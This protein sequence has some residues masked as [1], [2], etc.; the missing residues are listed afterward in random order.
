[1]CH[2]NMQ[3]LEIGGHTMDKT[4]DKKF[5][6]ESEIIPNV[7]SIDDVRKKILHTYPCSCL[8]ETKDGFQ[9]VDGKETIFM[10]DLLFE[11]KLVDDKW[12]IY[13]CDIFNF[14]EKPCR[15]IVMDESI[16]LWNRM[17]KILRVLSVP[18]DYPVVLVLAY[19]AA[20]FI[21]YLPSMK[22][23]KDEPEVLLRIYR[24]IIYYDEKKADVKLDVLISSE[25]K[26]RTVERKN[27]VQ[28]IQACNK[29]TDISI[30]CNAVNLTDITN[31]MM[32]CKAVEKAKEYIRNG[33]IYQVQLCR[34]VGSNADILPIDLYD[35]LTEINPAPYMFYMDIGEK[36]LISS[37][38]ELMLRSQNGMVQV[39]P[40]AGT[41]S[42][43]DSRGMC[44][45]CI[46]KENAE[47]LMLVDLVR[48]DLAR[49][50]VPGGVSV[51]S[52]MKVETYGTLY[53]LVSTV[54]TP[55]R[56]GCDIWD[57]ITSNFPAGTMTGA[58]KVRAME[59]IAE[60]ENEPRGLF[61][62]CVGYIKGNNEGVLALTI[63]TI[64]GESKN[65]LL[66]AAA[67]IVS[68]SLAEAEWEETGAKI[69]SFARALGGVK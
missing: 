7:A 47:H 29:K 65:Y 45:D 27:L 68:D 31:K 11:I 17:R 54:E 59:I 49:C 5:V 58:P 37:S 36:Y 6:I 46:P 34:C 30:K 50:A 8:F 38:P 42:Q 13:T 10:I 51:P 24:H 21:E 12:Y 2:G 52:F 33:D 48:N 39:R 60:L 18:L 53:H 67:G 44:L 9:A 63:R 20:R 41:M 1:M 19:S 62:G 40:I 66:R 64:I 14:A 25:D 4:R 56:A 57:L 23:C 32:F 35:R 61:T 3:E 16:S 69:Q 28:L 22:V 15:E 43:H 55:I 26:K